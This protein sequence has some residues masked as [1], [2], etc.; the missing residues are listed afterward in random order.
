VI[1]LLAI[2]NKETLLKRGLL[3]R[4]MAQCG[5]IENA[6]Y[7]FFVCRVPHF[8]ICGEILQASF[9]RLS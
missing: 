2:Y 8:R 4:D 9:I 6:S 3:D 5:I 1:N 7:L